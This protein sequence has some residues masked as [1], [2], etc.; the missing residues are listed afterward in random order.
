MAFKRDNALVTASKMEHLVYDIKC[1]MT[2]NT[3]KLDEEKTDIIILNGPRRLDIELSYLI[4]GNESV[5]KSTSTTLLGM[6]LD[7]TL[8]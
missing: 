8:C 3:L 7:S 5:P 2:Y 6:K 1:W 4:A